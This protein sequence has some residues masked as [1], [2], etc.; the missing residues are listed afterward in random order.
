MTWIACLFKYGFEGTTANKTYYAIRRDQVQ[1]SHTGVFY[2]VSTGD[3]WANNGKILL[4]SSQQAPNIRDINVAVSVTEMTPSVPVI[5]TT[6][7]T[8]KVITSGTASFAS[9]TVIGEASLL[10]AEPWG[11]VNTN[12]IAVTRDTFTPV[13]VPAGGS[14]TVQFEMWFNAMPS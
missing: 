9:E 5:S 2:R 7:N 3:N 14:I 4:G 12:R 1:V 8:I 13:T 6:G 11:T 10:L